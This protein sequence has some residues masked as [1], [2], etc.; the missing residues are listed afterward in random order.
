MDVLDDEEMPLSM[1]LKLAAEGTVSEE[2]EPDWMRNHA[3]KKKPQRV[4]WTDDSDPEDILELKKVLGKQEE[5]AKDAKGAEE[6]KKGKAVREQVA[7]PEQQTKPVVE[8]DKQ[9]VEMPS[10]EEGKEAIK[11]A[12]TKEVMTRLPIILP[13][14]ISRNKVLVECSGQDGSATDLSGDHG[15]VGRIVVTGEKGKEDVALD[16]KGTIY[17]L[18][19]APSCTMCVLGLTGSELKVEAM[20]NDFV[21]LREQTNLFDGE[22]GQGNYQGLFEGDDDEEDQ[23]KR[24]TDRGGPAGGRGADPADTLDK[25]KGKK[26]A[27]KIDVGPRKK[28]RTAATASSTKT[29]GRGRGTRGG[30]ARGVGRRGKR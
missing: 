2:D 13:E 30:S 17:S 27:I 14:K 20:V 8:E 24:A 1:R 25:G 22:V 19:I 18:S 16:L 5:D 10:K 6:R 3:Q 4:V 23:N 7:K 11:T 26:R 28:A 29:R 15:A 21:Q 12:G 9:M